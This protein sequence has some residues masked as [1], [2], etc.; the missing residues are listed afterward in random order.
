MESS[1]RRNNIS[2]G[3]N[4]PPIDYL[5]I[6]GLLCARVLADGLPIQPFATVNGGRTYLVWYT[7][8]GTERIFYDYR[9]AGPGSPPNFPFGLRTEP[10][11]HT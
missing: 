3:L 11:V 6:K 10:D 8:P 7:L 5:R 1:W 9:Y 4:I 2:Y